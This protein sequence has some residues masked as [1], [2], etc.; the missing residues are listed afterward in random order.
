MP[1]FHLRRPTPTKHSFYHLWVS[2]GSL[3]LRKNPHEEVTREE[4]RKVQL[5]DKNQILSNRINRAQGCVCSEDSIIT[6]LYYVLGFGSASAARVLNMRNFY[7][8]SI[9]GAD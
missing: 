8:I 2:T 9:L 7:R 1:L 4:V 5:D 3:Q 6:I